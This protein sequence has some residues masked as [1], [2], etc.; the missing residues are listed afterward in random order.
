MT[1]TR[2]IGGYFELERGY[3]KPRLGGAYVNSG[4]NALRLIIRTLKITRLHVPYYTCP[5][6]PKT[7]LSEGC[8][9]IPYELDDKL[10]PACRFP[11]DEF[12]LANDYFGLT[13]ANV[14]QL[15]SEYPNLIVDNAQSYFANPLGRAAF[16]SPRKF[17]GLPDGGIAM[18]NRDEAPLPELTQD[19]SAERM[20]HLLK[21][22]DFGASAAYADFK[23]D[24]EKLGQAPLRAMS[25]LTQAIFSTIDEESI[26]NRR[27]SNFSYLFNRLKTAFPI[28]NTP[29]EAP[30]VF[31]FVSHD[32]T[33][34]QRLIDAQI[35]V[36]TYWPNC[37]HSDSLVNGIIPIPID[38]RYG[39]SEMD[40][41]ISVLN[42]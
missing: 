28:A 19:V 20:A 2:P 33:L 15:A 5:V 41:I 13:G 32:P 39:I 17:F 35:F 24:E 3:F 40:T 10:M 22:H 9:V 25:N 12:I 8:E 6:V 18:F 37:E 26:R 14:A 36:A 29:E 1:T 11:K 31:P 30:L 27:L 34:R 42:G 16:Y 4:C 38:Q 21:R 23:A 7:V